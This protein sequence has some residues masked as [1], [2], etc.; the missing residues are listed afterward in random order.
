MPNS[1]IKQR[2]LHFNSFKSLTENYETDKINDET[3]F[4]K[5]YK[6]L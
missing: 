4:D 2:F 5:G 3:S 6:N 1:L